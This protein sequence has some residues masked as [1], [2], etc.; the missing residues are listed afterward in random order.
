MTAPTRI[1]RH[2]SAFLILLGAAGAAAAQGRPDIAWMRGGH[3]SWIARLVYSSDGSF[4]VSAGTD[5]TIKI[6]RASDSQLLRTLIVPGGTRTLALSPDNGTIC[7]GGEF[8]DLTLLIRCWRV[9]DGAELWTAA[10]PGTGPDAYVYALDFSPDGQRLASATDTK[11]LIWRASDGAF[12]ADFSG[13]AAPNIFAGNLAYSPDGRFL[14]VNTASDYPRVAF[15][16]PNSGSL[17]WDSGGASASVGYDIAFSPDSQ[18]VA[19]VNGIG[20]HVF[21]TTDHGQR[22]FPSGSAA[23]DVGFSPNG[24]RLASG[25]FGNVNLWNTSTQALIHSWNGH[26]NP[27]VNVT[28]LAFSADSTKLLSALLDIKRWNASDG[29]FDALITAQEGPVSLMAMSANEQVV[30]TVAPGNTT[31]ANHTI[32]L[33]RTSDGALL[34]YIDFGGPG[35]LR[36]LALSPDGKHVAAADTDQ[37]RI[38]NVTTGKLEHTHVESGRTSSYRPLA[39]T[40]DGT[41]IAESGDDSYL[42]VELW[43][44]TTDTVTTIAGGP[45]SALRFLPD[46]R[47]ALVQ[48]GYP[49]LVRVVTMT[50]HVDRQWSSLSSVSQLAVSA[51]GSMVAATGGDAAFPPGYVA[52]V[53][54]VTDGATLQTFVGHTNALTGIGFA[55]DGK[56]AATASRDGTVRIWRVSDG[57]QLHLYDEETYLN[58]EP[59][60]TYEGLW[61]LLAS[62]R[63]ARFVY[64]RGDATTV[65][66][67]NPEAV[68][69]ITTFTVPSKVTGCKPAT[70]KIVLDRPA[71]VAGLTISLASGSGEVTVPR[72]L[73]FNGGTTQKT[74]KITTTAVSAGETATISATLGSQTANASLSLRPIGLAALTLSAATVKGGTSVDGGVTLECAAGPDDVVVT[75]SSSVPSAAQPAAPTLTIPH[76][77]LTGAFSVTTSAV[78]A[79]KKPAIKGKTTPDALTKSKTL[80][81]TP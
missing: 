28:P 52:R 37:L 16:D 75:L 65:L 72:T 42:N 27:G 71:P 35:F 57:A 44:P 6:W 2:I 46:G 21:G 11:I 22:P 24:S 20:L 34:R 10:V 58:G 59:S 29:S 49:P 3:A 19:T 1:V 14:A 51:D 33:F 66:A 64:G 23:V 61:S 77:S 30:A 48:P 5:R 54:R 79:T 62:T 78:T 60:H 8:P 56:T 17:I 53:W 15:L 38:W 69:S 12:L 50:G 26:A 47:L 41:A 9:A 74:F 73:I 45:A 68:P 31:A 76:G 63:S 55:W 7:S 18:L 80:T 70:G 13:V 25:Y 81:V 67:Q 4:F 36:G 40:P 32:S 39:Y 43:H